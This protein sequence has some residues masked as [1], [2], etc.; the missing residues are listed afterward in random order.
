[1]KQKKDDS[2]HIERLIPKAVNGSK[3][4]LEKIVQGIQKSVYSLAL[5]M[6][7]DPQDAEDVAQEILITIIT[8]LQGFRFEGS[9]RA[10]VLRIAANKIKAARKTRAEKKMAAVENLDEIMDRYEA[11]GW[12]SKPLDAPEA[13][14]E[15][16]TRSICTHAL[17][18]S[19]DRTSR[20]AF[21][22]GVV[23]EVSSREGAQ[24]LEISEAAFRKRLSRARSKIRN[25]LR[26][27]CGIFDKSNRCQCRHILPGYLKGGWINPDKPVF[28]DKNAKVDPPE[29]LGHYMQE[30]EE[31]KQLSAIYNSLPA[32]KFDF[33]QAVRDIYKKNR[34]RI[35]TDP[36]VT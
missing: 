7:L 3:D 25:F 34:Y 28:T 19:L 8:N 24:I 16:E 6:L 23:M 11:R 22:L 33:V 35:I 36:R 27:N 9:F 13:Y 21:I 32:A 2:P 30:M 17:L 31:L 5:R 20:M 14:L 18:S 1:M 15:V 4:A 10:W 12:F 26:N 29:L